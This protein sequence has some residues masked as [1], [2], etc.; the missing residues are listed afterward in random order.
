M[1]SI[2]KLSAN[3]RKLT[4]PPFRQH[5]LRGVGGLAEAEFGGSE[6]AA[7]KNAGFRLRAT[8]YT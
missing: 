5:T 2:N 7:G 8:I 3:W 6:M 4:F 1:K